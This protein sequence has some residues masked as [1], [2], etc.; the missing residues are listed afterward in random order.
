[1]KV[2]AMRNAWAM[3]S[4]LGL[5]AVIDRK[6]PGA[7]VAE[8]LAETGQILRRGDEAELPDAAF[9]QRR[10]RVIDHR[11]VIDRLELL[12]RHQGQR[13]QPRTGATG[14]DYAF[15][16]AGRISHA[17]R[18]ATRKLTDARPCLPR[19]PGSVLPRT[20]RHA[21][22]RRRRRLDVSLLV[23]LQIHL[24]SSSS[25]R[26]AAPRAT[27]RSRRSPGRS[28]AARPSGNSRR[29]CAGAGDAA[30]RAWRRPR[31]C[32]CSECP[33]KTGPAQAEPRRW[34]HPVDRNRRRRLPPPAPP[35]GPRD[36][37][38]RCPSR[39]TSKKRGPRGSA[40]EPAAAQTVSRSRT[41]SW[42]SVRL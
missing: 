34:Q 10:Q 15:H 2:S 5:L 36:R 18:I 39:I 30:P 32:R 22:A 12:A 9:D 1:M 14:Q 20:F 33:G 6:P 24:T 27:S 26:R 11:F 28:S 35:T 21:L 3:P 38:D 31:T 23:R 41:R 7:A 37:P 4:R 40:A 29:Y 17:R 16:Q 8:Q 19:C 13:K 42:S 25:G